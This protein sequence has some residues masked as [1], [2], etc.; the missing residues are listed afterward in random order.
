MKVQ[1]NSTSSTREHTPWRQVWQLAGPDLWAC[2]WTLLRGYLFGIAAVGALV[3]L[4]WPLKLII[5]HV[6]AGH[7]LPQPLILTIQ[8]LSDQ[9]GMVPGR[10]HLVIVF[11]AG[12]AGIALFATLCGAAEK[13]AGARVRERMVLSLRD[14]VLQ[15]FQTLSCQ[16]RSQRCSG[17]LGLHILVDVHHLVRLLS[18]TVPL[19]FRHLAITVFTLGVMYMI[20]PLL[21]DAGLIM[22]VILAVLVRIKGTRLRQSSRLKRV[23]EGGVAGFT[24]EF[25][26]GMD[27]VQAM[28][29][30]QHVRRRFR[31]LNR[32]SLQSGL[33]ETADAV[34]MER[35]M[36]LINGLAVALIMGC[37][38]IMVVRGQLTLGEMTVF[39]AYMI[40]LLK[41]V[42]K[43]NEMAAAVSRGL[44]RAEHLGRLL[45]Q[46][47]AIADLPDA[48]PLDGC[49]G[50]IEL[51]NVSF[52][53]PGCT[54]PV[55]DC[56]DLRL[57]PGCLTVLTGPSGSGK[58][59]LLNLI[60]RQLIPTAGEILIDGHP[61]ARVTLASLR[62]QFGVMLQHHHLFAGSVR[63]ALW[64]N[65]G[66]IDDAGIWQVLAMVDLAGHV[67]R[68]PMGLDT[69]LKEGGANLSG[70]QLARLSLARALLTDR[71]ILLLDEPLANI[72]HASQAVILEALEQI[73][74]A[75]TIFAISHQPALLE[76]ADVVLILE[77]GR[78]NQTFPVSLQLDSCAL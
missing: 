57:E 17:D 2:R 59:T 69:E 46:R 13:M 40:Q 18:K 30:E 47:P 14:K 34:G 19:V 75:R 48:Q 64:L 24:H 33:A 7:R 52:S 50:S 28:G 11:A 49:R 22:V 21:A 5:D 44:T 74:H 67:Q 10:E 70:G 36:Q 3:L 6:V 66:P 23:R 58:S 16:Q 76:R 65:D 12:Y 72:D 73:R 15:H 71:P 35:A 9:F 27:T 8:W 51:R 4:P 37:S 43:I 63:D 20:E 77:R 53:Y 54:N 55:L 32:A 62:A 60:L 41:P 78:L 26:R 38:G 29:A 39:V 1:E 56:V 42:E 45:S 25:V 61:Y 68:M 31:D